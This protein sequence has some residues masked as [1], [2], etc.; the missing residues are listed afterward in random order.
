MVPSKYSVCVCPHSSVQ[1]LPKHRANFIC[2][3]KLRSLSCVFAGNFWQ[4]RSRNPCELMTNIEIIGKAYSP[5]LLR[6]QCNWFCVLLV[7]GSFSRNENSQGRFESHF[8]LGFYN[9][10]QEK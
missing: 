6:A 5:V 9:H 3:Q 4:A 7:S 8:P 1:T 2:G 10:Q